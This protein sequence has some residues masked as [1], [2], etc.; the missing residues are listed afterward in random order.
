MCS[1]IVATGNRVFYSQSF[2]LFSLKAKRASHSRGLKG[3]GLLFKLVC[4][5]G[6]PVLAEI[7]GIQLCERGE[8]RGIILRNMFLSEKKECRNEKEAFSFPSYLL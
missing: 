6:D 8:G 4:R 5:S 1:I 7:Q 2:L 3:R